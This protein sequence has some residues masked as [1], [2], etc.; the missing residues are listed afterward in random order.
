MVDVTASKAAPESPKPSVTGEGNPQP[1][2]PTGSTSPA[3]AG[4][5]EAAT[6]EAE[7]SASKRAKDA[8]DKARKG[9]QKNRE[10]QEQHQRLEQQRQYEAQQSQQLQAQLEQA[11]SYIRMLTQDP[12]TA[13]KQL[14]VSPEEIAKRMAMDGSPEA[15]INGLKEQI[16][17][18]RAEL[19]RMQDEAQGKQDALRREQLENEYKQEAQNPRK[20]PNLASVHPDF[21]LAATEKLIQQL[22]RKGYDPRRFSNHDLLQY[23]DSTYSKNEAK[24]ETQEDTS[25]SDAP[26]KTATIT[27]K[28]QTAKHVAPPDPAKMTDRQWKK[29]AAEELKRTAIK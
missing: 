3:A 21:I 10:L 15:Q 6:S 14:G 7:V 18:Q 23:L 27:N 25:P 2:A 22:A 12:V 4:T 8:A 24:M 17:A 13:M 5:E 26:K 28:L 20:Y 16:Q 1:D 9:A 11:N 29:W 19:K